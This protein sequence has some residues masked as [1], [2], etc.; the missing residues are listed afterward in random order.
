MLTEQEQSISDLLLNLSGQ[1]VKGV[2]LAAIKENGDLETAF[3]GTAEAQTFLGTIISSHVHMAIHN[4]IANRIV[5]HPS[6]GV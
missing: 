1:N 2:I 6:S 4:L 5:E 3:F